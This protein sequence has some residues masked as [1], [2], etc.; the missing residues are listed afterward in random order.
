MIIDRFQKKAHVFLGLVLLMDVFIDHSVRAGESTLEPVVRQIIPAVVRVTGHMRAVGTN[1]PYRKHGES[2]GFLFDKKGL[3][4]TVYSTYV[5]PKT[6]TMCEKFDIELYDGRILSARAFAVDPV[7]NFAIL[8]ITEEGSYAKLD[9][10][11]KPT[12]NP[13]EEVWAVAGKNSG[14]EP[15]SFSGRI[16]AKNKTSVYG[17][18]F[19]DLLIDTYMELPEYA[20]GGPLMN[21]SGEVLG[22]NMSVTDQ[23]AGSETKSIEEHAIP[24]SAILPILK[25][26][27]ANPT[28]E[29][30]WMGFSTR[31]LNIKE[32]ALTRQLLKR[33]GGV[34]IDFVWKDSPAARAGIHPGDILVGIDG[35]RVMTTTHFKGLLFQMVNDTPELKIV[36]DGKVLHKQI[37]VVKRPPWAA[38]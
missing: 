1:N 23:S 2:S 14:N 7:L 24:V 12:M 34:S 35:G 26:L 25:V 33:R 29:Q 11:G 5:E 8:E 17:D 32:R 38:L 6:K 31:N 20:Y 28:F 9:I 30:R 13:G 16:K 19:G 18:G 10:H 27:L 21:K 15:L 36:R 22:I 37:H 4:F 3:L